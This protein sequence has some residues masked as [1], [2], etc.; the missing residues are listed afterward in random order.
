[1]PPAPDNCLHANDISAA[2][3]VKEEFADRGFRF[4]SA[5]KAVDAAGV[6]R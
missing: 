1:M 5:I 2:A 3:L 4:V 6:F